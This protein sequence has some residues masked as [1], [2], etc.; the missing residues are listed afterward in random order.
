MA[1]PRTQC[2]IVVDPTQLSDIRALAAAR[3]V[4]VR[5]I[6]ERGVEPVTTVT[7]LLVGAVAAVTA[8]QRL[9]EQRKGGQVIDLRRSGRRAFYRTPDL[10]YGIVV[11][12]AVDG[13][14]RVEVKDPD[15][16]FGKTISILQ[17][18]LPGGGSAQQAVGAITKSLGS[19]VLVETVEDPPEDVDE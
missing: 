18:I 3:G 1:E 7:V 5:Q 8:L 11:I 19:E 15:G 4:E 9:V 14:V 13:E 17:N 6:P 16:M 2:V 12:I 10:M